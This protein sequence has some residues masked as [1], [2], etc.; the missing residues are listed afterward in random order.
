MAQ[1]ARWGIN[2]LFRQYRVP[3]RL[4]QR[5]ELCQTVRVMAERDF[6]LLR[7]HGKVPAMASCAKCE[8][9]FF[10]PNIYSRDPVGAHE[11]LLSKFD[12]HDCE[13]KPKSNRS[14]RALA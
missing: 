11:Y 1:T 7:H 12:R 10:T 13:E 6:V 4:A 3:V 2:A 8:R 5:L 9:K 14:W